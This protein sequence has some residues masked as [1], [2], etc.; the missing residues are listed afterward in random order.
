MRSEEDTMKH[1]ILLLGIAILSMTFTAC[2]EDAPIG[3]PSNGSIDASVYVA[4]GNSLTAG[5][6][7]GALFEEA[8]MYSFPN[9]IAQQIGTAEFVQP[10]IAYPGTGDLMLLQQIINGQP[11][12]TYN[13]ANLAYPTNMTTHLKP[14]HNLGIPGSILADAID[15]SDAVV[16]G[17]QRANPFY[18]LVLRDQSVFGKSVLDQAIALQPTLMTFWF[19]CND[20]FGYAASGGT[21]GTNIGV[22]GHPRGTMP[23][24]RAVFDEF[25]KKAFG[26]MKLS[27]P[28]AKVLVGNIP[29][30][31]KNPLFF[32]VPRKIPNPTNPEQ[33]LDIYYHTSSDNVAAVGENDYVLLT[34]QAELLKGVG[35]H[36]NN[37]LPSQYVLDAAEVAIAEDAVEKFNMILEQEAAA[38]GYVLVDV[39]QLMSDL[40]S[41]GVKVAGETYTS[42]YI[43]GGVFSLDGVH[44]M[45]RGNALVANYF[46]DA[47]NSA[48]GANIRM[49]APN[50][51]P[52]FTA[53]SG[54]G[55]R[56]VVPW[57]LSVDFPTDFHRIFGV[58]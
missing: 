16:R 9:L 2:D 12:I 7:S 44:L 22:G 33:M 45:P 34:A 51:V 23:T 37:P 10:T 29:N 21:R 41:G 17:T 56:G 32:T 52:G 1:L 40:N 14:Y 36:P 18:A 35:L 30:V 28:D 54:M 6:Q 27:I 20:V 43:T 25:I 46:I 42:N 5:Y 13:G 24:E 11:V 58:Q 48:Y 39:N 15:T 31:T 4:V 49:I 57:R 55:K 47:M 53:P 38:H 3:D 8:Q 26:L 19:G 50:T